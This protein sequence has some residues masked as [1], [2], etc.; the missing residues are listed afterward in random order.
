MLVSPQSFKIWTSSSSRVLHGG[1][2][3]YANRLLFPFASSQPAT[4]K[5]VLTVVVASDE[6]DSLGLDTDESY[7]LSV[8]ASPAALL[9]ANTVFGALHGLE[10]FSQLIKWDD[11]KG[12]YSIPDLPIHI[13]DY[14]RFPWRYSSVGE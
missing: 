7:T 10:T 5:F 2:A 12:V 4:A 1:I 14:P 8:Y 13:T 11:L 6:D 3:R 9:E